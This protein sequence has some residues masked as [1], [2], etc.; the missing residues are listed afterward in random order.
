MNFLFL[1]TT[2]LAVSIDSFVCGFSLGFAAKK[3]YFVVLGIA[4]TVFCMCLIT[5]CLGAALSGI[6]TEDV[7]AL[8]GLVLIGVAVFNLISGK[9]ERKESGD[10]FR[11]SLIIGFAVGLDGACANFSLA[12]MGY[13]GLYVPALIAL[14]HAA[15]I[16]LGIALSGTRALR[17]FRK[18]DFIPPYLLIVLGL[19]KLS[20]LF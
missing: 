10:L 1:F 7:A 5:D 2:A 16:Y 11:E 12:L 8:G 3:K 15:M 9:K 14:L 6:L 18:A 13:T 4:L 19:Y 17:L 20:A